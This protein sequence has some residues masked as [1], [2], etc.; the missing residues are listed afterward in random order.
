MKRMYDNGPGLNFDAKPWSHTI[1]LINSSIG[2]RAVGSADV[3]WSNGTTKFFYC[4]GGSAGNR[5]QGG[6]RVQPFVGG[7]FWTDIK[8]TDFDAYPAVGAAT[9]L[10]LDIGS[11]DT[12]AIPND[13][14]VV[15]GDSNESTIVMTNQ[16]DDKAIHKVSIFGTSWLNL[17]VGF[18]V[19][20]FLAQIQ[21]WYRE[22]GWTET[23]ENGSEMIVIPSKYVK[24]GST[25][26][27]VLEEALPP[28]ARIIYSDNPDNHIYVLPRAIVSPR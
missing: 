11:D 22:K 27:S 10:I 1:D 2:L 19:D 26:V 16:P 20:G 6:I 18:D 25:L 3:Q 17:S 12:V 13:D 24:V 28:E 8:K 23:D 4:K 9:E 15:K 21:S 5:F 14:V 7:G